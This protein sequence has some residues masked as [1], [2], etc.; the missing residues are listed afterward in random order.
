[1]QTLP[2]TRPYE[3]ARHR[4][5]LWTRP[6]HIHETSHFSSR[7][8]AARSFARYCG[9]VTFHL[10]PV[11][12]AEGS[13]A[14]PCPD[15]TRPA[16]RAGHDKRG[17][18]ESHNSPPALPGPTPGR[19]SVRVLPCSGQSPRTAAVEPRTT[20]SG[21][22]TYSVRCTGLPPI[23]SSSAPT[24]AAAIA[25]T[26]WRTVVSGGSVKAM[27]CESSKP[28]TETS[29]GTSSPL[30]GRRARRPGPSGRCRRRCRC[31]PRPTGRPPPPGR[32]RR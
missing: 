9:P 31:T 25:C 7:F 22:K 30:P 3:A 24:A 26:G 15:S 6:A 28:T 29:R 10:T 27:S 8:L 1:M 11:R 32:P 18:Q 20:S 17:V 4:S 23:S 19:L 5:T 14:S 21:W 2:R 12:S 16:G 13:G